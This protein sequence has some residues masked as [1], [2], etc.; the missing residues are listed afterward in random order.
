MRSETKQNEK[1]QN[2][3]DMEFFL[4]QERYPFTTVEKVSMKIEVKYVCKTSNH[5]LLT[6]L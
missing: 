6:N 3:I 1:N 4:Q 5:R 2:T